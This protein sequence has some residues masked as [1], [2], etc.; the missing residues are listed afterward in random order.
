MTGAETIKTFLVRAEIGLEMK[1]SRGSVRS[2]RGPRVNHDCAGPEYQ[3][4]D[5]Y[6]TANTDYV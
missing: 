4:L 3:Y 6:G 1:R 2:T 5:W